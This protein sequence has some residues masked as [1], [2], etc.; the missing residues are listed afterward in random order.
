VNPEADDVLPVCS[1]ALVLAC[2][3]EVIMAATSIPRR[4]FIGSVFALPCGQAVQSQRTSPSRA[5]AKVAAGAGRFNEVLKLPAGDLLFIK[6][7]T[8][9]T[10]GALFI[11][12]Q[13]IERRG[14]GP[15][16][17]YHENEDEWLSIPRTT[18]SRNGDGLD[19]GN[20][21]MKVSD[22]SFT[23]LRKSGGV[24]GVRVRTPWF[25]GRLDYGVPFD[26]RPGETSGRFFFS[27]GQAF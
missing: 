9:D 14:S 12:E 7:A 15:P 19:V 24:G 22:F 25:L 10:G 11:T 8:D 13:P 4:S 27:I 17:H 2:R 20:V 3:E 23:E 1:T 26:R 6:L 5:V 16:K 18:L 21:F